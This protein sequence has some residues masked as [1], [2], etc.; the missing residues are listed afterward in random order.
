MINICQAIISDGWGGAE[1][2]A[3]ELARHLGSRGN[4]VFIILNDEI[5]RNYQDLENVNLFNIGPLKSYLNLTKS[6]T[7]PRV[8]THNRPLFLLYAYLG[9]L[10][11]MTSYRRIL[12]GLRQFLSENHIAVIHA[13]LV[14]AILL[15][16]LLDDPGT[17]K[18]ATL[19]GEHDLTGSVSI[20]PLMKPI[21][22]KR[23]A[24]L[25]KALHRMDRITHVSNFTK[26]DT[27]R[28]WGSQLGSKSIVI[29]NGINVAQIQCKIQPDLESEGDF[30]I[31]FP[32]GAKPGK[33]GDILFKSLPK[34]RKEIANF[35]V[36]VAL[37]VPQNHR[38]RRMVKTLGLERNVTFVGF[39]PKSEYRKLLSSVNVLVLPS[40]QEAYPIS[41]LEAMA[42]GKPVVATN[43]GGIPE[44]IEDGRNGI[45]VS[46]DPER[47]AEAILS[48]YRDPVLRKQMSQNNL[49]DIMRHDWSL[50]VDQYVRLYQESL[51][52]KA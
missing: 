22:R 33:G 50:I 5:S 13:H 32:G 41:C 23:S 30:R 4:N 49:K 28:C 35:H 19:H 48:L 20:H 29:P 36:Y 17:V 42:L 38:L 11:A 16:S 39:L 3:Y 27:L 46:R 40:R 10:L 6:I 44:I 45:L 7:I 8:G 47:I 34:V 52:D 12:N 1:T 37:N 31:L 24:K 21:I 25:G 14:D 15:I 18:I 2:V 43:T 26:S 51:A 9:E